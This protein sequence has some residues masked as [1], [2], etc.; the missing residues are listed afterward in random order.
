ME[1]R[2]RE[3][4]GIRWG[5]SADEIDNLLDIFQCR[6]GPDHFFNRSATRRS[7]SS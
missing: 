1:H 7:A 5:I 3:R 4:C 2:F 6:K